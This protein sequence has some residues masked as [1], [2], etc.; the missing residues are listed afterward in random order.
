MPQDKPLEIKQ[1]AAVKEA[2]LQVQI[3]M[4][5]TIKLLAI[6]TVLVCLLLGRFVR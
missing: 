3:I 6:L 1:K 4:L 2:Q 5:M